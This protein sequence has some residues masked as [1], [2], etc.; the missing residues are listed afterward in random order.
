M[1]PVIRR[2]RV[3]VWDEAYRQV[4]GRTVETAL[5]WKLKEEVR[6]VVYGGVRVAV[7]EQLRG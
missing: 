2:M 6:D 3:V 5:W 4:E 1:K 7:R